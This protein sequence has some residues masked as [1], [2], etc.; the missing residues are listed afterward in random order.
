MQIVGRDGKGE[1]GK[2]KDRAAH[3]RARGVAVQIV[4]DRQAAHTFAAVQRVQ[5]DA[6]LRGEEVAFEKRS[7]FFNG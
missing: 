4:P 2:R 6:V 1:I 3:Y 7:R 5:R